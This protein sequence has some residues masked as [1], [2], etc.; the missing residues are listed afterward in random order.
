MLPVVSRQEMGRRHCGQNDFQQIIFCSTV[1]AQNITWQLLRR[2]F[3]K[4]DKQHHKHEA[5]TGI[6]IRVSG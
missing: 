3:S 4:E 5:Q 6:T 1:N 2:H